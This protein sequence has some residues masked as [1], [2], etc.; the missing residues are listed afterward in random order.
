MERI[1]TRIALG[2]VRPREL[3]SLRDALDLLPAIAGHM[4]KCFNSTPALVR[5]VAGLAV[6]PDLALLL[7]RAID[8]E[9]AL[10]VRGGD[11]K[12]GVVGKGGLGRVKS[13][14]SRI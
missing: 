3:A 10:L 9:P 6:P 14:G 13:W 11:R 12:S 4:E 8:A 7:T 5:L 1:A 2:S